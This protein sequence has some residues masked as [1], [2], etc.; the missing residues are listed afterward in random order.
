VE[1]V[2]CHIRLQNSL[3]FHWNVFGKHG[4]CR[5]ALNFVNK[6]QSPVKNFCVCFLSLLN[7]FKCVCFLSL[8]NEFKFLI[9]VEIKLCVVQTQL[10][11]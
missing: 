3:V 1:G 7:E 6:V 4:C 5:I 8:M 9:V 2:R 11:L 10:V